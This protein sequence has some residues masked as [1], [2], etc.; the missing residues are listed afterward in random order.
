MQKYKYHLSK[1]NLNII[2]K[3]NINLISNYSKLPSNLNT[4]RSTADAN[5]S[6]QP[7]AEESARIN[8]ISIRKHFKPSKHEELVGSHE[9]SI[10]TAF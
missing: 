6:V 8:Q 3:K 4:K 2:N 5:Q 9:Q 1:L 10:S 7:T